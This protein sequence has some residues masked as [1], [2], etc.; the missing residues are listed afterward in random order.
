MP[1]LA[2]PI[3]HGEALTSLIGNMIAVL[4]S[5]RNGFDS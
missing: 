5:A 4:I 2:M 1:D 3:Y